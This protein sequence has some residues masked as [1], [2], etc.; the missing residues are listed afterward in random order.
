MGTFPYSF[1]VCFFGYKVEAFQ[2]ELDKPNKILFDKLSELL[3][4]SLLMVF[5]QLT[6]KTFHAFLW[7]HFNIVMSATDWDFVI[8]L[9]KTPFRLTAHTTLVLDTAPGQ[10]CFCLPHNNPLSGG[11]KIINQSLN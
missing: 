11:V 1:L 8:K 9:A 3:R 6:I 7:T 5:T 2:L 4:Q 10:P